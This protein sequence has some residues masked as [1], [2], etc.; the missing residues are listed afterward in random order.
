MVSEGVWAAKSIH[1]FAQKNHIDLP[2]T[3]QIYNV[4]HENKPMSDALNDFLALI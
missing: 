2:L 1:Q 4:L 3:T